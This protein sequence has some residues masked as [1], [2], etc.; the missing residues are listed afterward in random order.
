MTRTGVWMLAAAVGAAAPAAVVLA[1]RPQA[2]DTAAIAK[3][4]DEALNRSQAMDALFWL[5]DRYG[6]RLNASPE[7]EE[8]GDWAV[9][10]LRKW[11]V[12]DAHKERWSFGRGWSLTGFHA[13]M[14]APRVM[15]IIGYPKAWSS[16]TAG[17]VT[18]DVVR[19]DIA[20]EADAAKYHGTLRGR[21]VLTQPAREVHMLDRG[22][23]TVLHYADQDGKW[24]KELFEPPPPAPARGGGRGRGGRG[25][26][27]FNVNQ[28]LKDEGVV[29]V[30]D[31]GSNSDLSSGGSGLSWQQ[32]HLD[33]GTI[34]VQGV[35]PRDGSVLPSVT[36][37]VEHYNRMVRLLEHNVPVT[38]ELNVGV[39]WTDEPAG[40]G[41]F[42]V[43]GDIPGT[44]LADQIVMIGAHFDSWHAATGATDNGTGDVA[45]MEAMRI[46][47]ALG[48]E[49]RRTIRIGLWGGEEE[50]EL[51]SRAYAREHLGT[52]QAPKPELAKTVAYFNLDNG[53]GRIRGVWMQGNP[54]VEPVFRR[55]AAPLADLGVNLFSPRPVSQTDHTTFDA[56]GIPAFQ[57]VQE[58]LEYNSRTHHS[59]MDVYDR[60][61]PDDLKEQATVAAVFAWLAATEDEPLPKKP[62]AG[63]GGGH[64]P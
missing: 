4:R 30:F 23:G 31:R 29:A 64:R 2:V 8:A 21:I 18:A 47:R 16:G 44:D 41:G 59:N 56:L 52:A 9:R 35:N 43:V 14:T 15:P 24:A 38:V 54:T 57:F 28:F 26:A 5:A 22:D 25:G 12:T 13:T 17:T 27:R 36:L 50:G 37:A 46:I 20:S 60:V 63:A 42:N 1:G 45:M 55:W 33:G 49:P 62:A 6:P 51:G 58:R 7:F 39:R 48:L 10:Q 53:T 40:G 19:V 11:G 32:Q 3:I 34:F 61:Q